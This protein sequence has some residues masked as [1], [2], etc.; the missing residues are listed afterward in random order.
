MERFKPFYATV[1]CECYQ[2]ETDSF[3]LPRRTAFL[4]IDLPTAVIEQYKDRV[5]IATELEKVATIQW[6]EGEAS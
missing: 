1:E 4:R 3:G 5:F 2:E 6:L